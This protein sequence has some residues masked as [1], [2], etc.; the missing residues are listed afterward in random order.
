MQNLLDYRFGKAVSLFS[1]LPNEIEHF[2]LM[3]C[4][5]YGT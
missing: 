2:T 5:K 4:H 3:A 1:T